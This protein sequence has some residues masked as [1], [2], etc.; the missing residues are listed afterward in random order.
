[1][2]KEMLYNIEHM[3]L[4]PALNIYRTSLVLSL[5][6]WMFGQ[7]VVQEKKSEYVYS[8]DI[9]PKKDA[10]AFCCLGNCLD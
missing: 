6:R 4:S 10:L 7:Y 5:P 3:T 8:V 2:S 9:I 1:M